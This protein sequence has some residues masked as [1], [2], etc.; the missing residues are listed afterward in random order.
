M[1]DTTEDRTF[2]LSVWDARQRTILYIGA[3]YDGGFGIPML[4]FPAWATGLLGLPFPDPGTIW[5]RLDGIF[6][7][8]MAMIYLVTARDPARYLGNVGVALIGKAA[9]I[10]FYFAYVF[11]AGETKVFILFAVLD[12]IMLGL[13]YWALGPQGL[14]RFGPA[15]RPARPARAPA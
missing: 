3:V 11:L 1:S 5:L 2:T 9:S 12:A 8:V 13:H 10:V 4:F 14:K 7:L 15:L 6:L